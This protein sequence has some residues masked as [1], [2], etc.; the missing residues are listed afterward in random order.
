MS[1]QFNSHK[2]RSNHDGMN[3]IDS[4]RV[5]RMETHQ[6]LAQRAAE[7]NVSADLLH[8]PARFDSSHDVSV[9]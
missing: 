2:D 8:G 6:W 3:A 9:R 1:E 7:G 4:D 5:D